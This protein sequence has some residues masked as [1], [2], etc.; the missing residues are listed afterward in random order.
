MM[1][2][3]EF[4]NNEFHDTPPSTP[5]RPAL[6]EVNSSAH[7]NLAAEL[8]DAAVRLD[9]VAAILLQQGESE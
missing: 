7:R 3:R 1:S 6:P 9:R 2:F 5:R 4:A 8:R